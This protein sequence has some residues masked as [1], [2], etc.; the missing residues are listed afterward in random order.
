MEKDGGFTLV[1]IL[2][3]ILLLGIAT[4]SLSSV[5]ISIRNIQL[6]SSYYDT[7]NRAAAREIE[8]LRNDSYATLTAGQTINFT[9][10]L[11]TTLPNRNG[12]VVVSAPTDGIRR[13][14]ATVTYKAQGKT[15]TLTLS[16]LI[17]EI[18]ITQ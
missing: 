3:T 9:A 13:V 2:V 5:F 10:D 16:S 6:Q 11:P 1:E 12:T 8:S 7:A 15:R 14:D 18:G 4:A 17:G